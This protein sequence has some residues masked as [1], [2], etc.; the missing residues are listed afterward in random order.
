MK[1]FLTTFFLLFACIIFAQASPPILDPSNA[2]SILGY[3]EFYYVIAMP[4]LNWLLSKMWPSATKKELILKTSSFAIVVLLV[5]IFN[6]GF[7]AAIVIKAV[8]AF[9]AQVFAYDKILN[10]AG[11]SSESEHKK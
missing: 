7:T 6:K 2:D 11:L 8:G 5:I 3:W 10:P 4:L 1:Y 9:I